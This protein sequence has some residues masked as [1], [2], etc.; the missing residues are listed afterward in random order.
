MIKLKYIWIINTLFL[1]FLIAN[2][3]LAG[4]YFF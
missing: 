3:K 2:D 1:D 4:Y